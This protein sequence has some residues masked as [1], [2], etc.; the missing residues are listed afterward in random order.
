MQSSN[1]YEIPDPYV[2][3]VYGNILDQYANPTYVLTL[4]IPPP[5]ES[6]NT[7]TANDSP[8]ETSIDFERLDTPTILSTPPPVNSK[9]K[10]VVIAQTGVTA[11][12]ID[13]LEITATAH[14]DVP[15]MMTKINFTISQPGAANLFDQIQYARKYMGYSD[16][17]LNVGGVIFFQ[18][19]IEFKG[20]TNI[21][22]DESL[23]GQITN[24]AGPFSW[25]IIVH[26]VSVRIDQT[27]SYYDFQ[28][29]MSADQAL[30]DQFFKIPK[31]ITSRGKTITEHVFG[32]VKELNNYLAN[33]STD[34]SRPDEIVIDLS[35]LIG[36]PSNIPGVGGATGVDISTIKDETVIT[37]NSAAAEISNRPMNDESSAETAEQREQQLNQNPTDTGRFDKI[38][39]DGA[40]NIDVTEGTSIYDYVGMLLSMNDEF[41]S[42]ISRKKDINDPSSDDVNLDQ[43][44][45]YWYSVKTRVQYLA[46]DSRRKDYTK[47]ITFIPYILR[48]ARGDIVLTNNEYSYLEERDEEAVRV[49][50]KRLQDIVSMGNLRKA[51]YYLFTG[52]NDQILNLDITIDRTQT[53][54][55]PPKGGYTSDITLTSAQNLTVQNPINRDMS[56]NDVFKKAKTL[57]DGS[58]FKKGLN[59]L[60]NSATN[61]AQFANSLGRSVDELKSA[62]ADSTGRSAQLLV[63]SLESAQLAQASRSL[64]AAFL[65]RDLSDTPTE[66][67]SVIS[68]G[69]GDYVPEVSGQIYAS[70]FI[71]PNDSLTLEE[72]ESAGY[73]YADPNITGQS[74]PPTQNTEVNNRFNRATYDTSTPSNMLFGF[75][76]RQH[77]NVSFMH[78]I[79]IT[80][81]GDP[82]YLGSDPNTGRA[83]TFALKNSTPGSAAYRSNQNYFIL[84]IGTNSAFDLR[85]DDED[86]NSGYGTNNNISN[87]FSGVY[88]MLTVI[89]RFNRGIYTNEVSAF[90]E[91]TVPLHLIRPLKP[92]EVPTD[93]SNVDASDE[94]ARE[95]GVGGFGPG[96]TTGSEASSDGTPSSASTQGAFRAIYGNDPGAEQAVSSAAR[97]ALGL[98][99]NPTADDLNNLKTFTPVPIYDSNVALRENAIRLGLWARENGLRVDE[100]ALLAEVGI[101]EWNPTAHRGAGH[102]ENR[103]FD[104]NIGF[105]NVEAN[106]P[107]LGMRM[108]YA[109]RAL[110]NAGYNVIWRTS[111]HEGHLHFEI[112]RNGV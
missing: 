92:G 20:Y 74:I 58:L 41:K 104:L 87:S 50:T 33:N 45:V 46:W 30:A 49:A 77:L 99:E 101:G 26:D 106:D 68:E 21:L 66:N 7:S 52:K 14:S 40:D 9:K 5:P 90:K 108:D 73:V 3:R 57:A 48:T 111:G 37:S 95:L 69:F 16:Q 105:G 55:M 64:D 89:S 91:E 22:D 54:I 34:Y 75:L 36:T 44:F 85:I 2:G 15:H 78:K 72:L 35:E 38:A 93:F 84:Q 18:L 42:R 53:L 47:K 61:L 88:S 31:N 86:A 103:A 19:D 25:T 1:R 60:S 24:I 107:H 28:C 51:Y 10:K 17:Q 76:Y 27:G 71:T 100:N 94:R 70:D 56:L 110:R 109:A 102:K 97:Q 98:P 63:D 80:L 13:D 12:Q 112:P 6:F 11:T 67:S 29:V 65:S 82:W 62:I 96:S 32:F 39:A 59:Q 23:G 81:R 79:D 8:T 83:D 43:T 4:S